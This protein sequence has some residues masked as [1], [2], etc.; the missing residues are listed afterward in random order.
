MT[1]CPLESLR[2]YTGCVCSPVW[3]WLPWKEERGPVSCS[4]R[5]ITAFCGTL[6]SGRIAMMVLNRAASIITKPLSRSNVDLPSFR[7]R[8]SATKGHYRFQSP[9]D[10]SLPDGCH[11][12]HLHKVWGG[13]GESKVSWGWMGLHPCN[14]GNVVIGA[15]AFTMLW[16]VTLHVC[17]MYVWA[18]CR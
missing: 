14:Y 11:P 13:T 6:S 4:R 12:A 9:S 2:V 18:S 3:R 5:K 15:G 8:R 1:V 10:T 16:L 17:D 7:R